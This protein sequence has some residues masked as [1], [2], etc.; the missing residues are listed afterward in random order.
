M[1]EH[2]HPVQ[3]EKTDVDLG[4]VTKAGLAIVV[5]TV[6]TAL[7]LIPVIKTMKS[8]SERHD[9]ASA[10]IAGFGANRQPPEPR[11]QREPFGD[12]R[13]MKTQ[14]DELLSG[15]GWVDE[16]KGVAHIP[17]EEAMKRVAA[18]GL[19]SRP[20]PAASAAPVAPAATPVPAH[21]PAAEHHP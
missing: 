1:S 6:V 16:A 10:P 21:A 20:A 19:P 11:L 17:I 5:V 14:Q 8:R 13:T 9:P 18:Q 15:Y 7:A 2:G 4:A 3:Y 12:W